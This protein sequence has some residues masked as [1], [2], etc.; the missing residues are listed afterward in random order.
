MERQNTEK[1]SD[2]ELMRILDQASDDGEDDMSE[3]E[4]VE[5]RMSHALSSGI[6]KKKSKFHR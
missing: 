4:M 6:P 1:K 5:M 2:P 3:P